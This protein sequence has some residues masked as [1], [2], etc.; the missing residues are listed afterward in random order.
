M[1]QVMNDV[2]VSDEVKVGPNVVPM[3]IDK[4]KL[5]MMFELQHKNNVNTIPEYWIKNLAWNEAIIAESGELLES[6]QYKWWKSGE[7][8]L[9]NSRMELID[10][11]HFIMSQLMVEHIKKYSIIT[12]TDDFKGDV[13]E[14]LVNQITLIDHYSITE[15]NELT[16]LELMH[17][18]NESIKTTID[19]FN[20]DTN[21]LVLH[22]LTCIASF[23][24]S[25]N[26]LVELYITKNVLNHLRQN[27]G[28]KTGEYIKLWLFTD[29]SKEGGLPESVEDNVV[30]VS[31]AKELLSTNELTFDN[32][33]SKLQSY[34]DDIVTPTKVES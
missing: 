33:Y 5:M 15:N 30:A 3:I 9:D 19:P 4:D 31:L 34:Y 7:V 1:E 26:D 29:P 22:F 12:T 20:Y 32:L 18:I 16:R 23:G 21:D 17:V 25:F 28:Y 24:M 14:S 27:N 2:V 13:L 8:D 6:L 10:I 11:W